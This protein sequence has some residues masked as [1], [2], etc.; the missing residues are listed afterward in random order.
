M[1]HR[2]RLISRADTG[3]RVEGTKVF[4]EVVGEWF[5]CRVFP[6]ETQETEG[7]RGGRR[8]LM[9]TPHVVV[10]V[11]D[12]TGA[13]I[14]VGAIGPDKLIELNAGP[15]GDAVWQVTSSPQPLLTRTKLLGYY[16]G[17]RRVET[18]GDA[19]A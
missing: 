15:L 5:K 3:Q 1:T 11:K 13:A 10:G 16:F 2:G 14:D 12:L 7:V 17:V 8:M 19:G 4:S 18:A 6:D 9:K